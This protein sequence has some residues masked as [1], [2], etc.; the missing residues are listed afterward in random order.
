[1]SLFL[2]TFFTIYGGVHVYAYL[3][4]RN[5][6]SPGHV[7]SVL[8]GLFMVLMIVAP[9][10][11][12]V[13]EQGGYEFVA[14]V[15]A[16]LG[17]IWMALAFLFF[18]SSLAVDVINGSSILI[19][20]LIGSGARH[21]LISH[22]AAVIAPML[23]SLLINV[24][25]YFEARH[26]LVERLVIRT[27]KIP[28]DKIRIVQISD[29]HLGLIV[30]AE[31]LKKIIDIIKAEDPDIL[32]STGDLVDAQI[33]HLPGLSEMLR[34]VSARYGKFA[35]TGNHEYYAGIDRALLFI[36]DSGFKVLRSGA[37]YTGGISVVG[38]DDPSGIQ[39]GMDKRPDEA[40]VFSGLPKDRF[41]LVLRHRPVIGQYTEGLFDL[42]LSGH[43][44]KGQIFPFGYLSALSYPMNAGRF[45]LEGGSMLYV[46]RGTGT[47]GPPIRFLSPPEVT[48]ID[49]VRKRPHPDPVI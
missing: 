23:L 48:V 12:R 31:R 7:P 11:V 20:M 18:C 15:A 21:G 27:D 46:S 38:F 33:N 36:K 37:V 1:M 32:V 2:L 39:M 49:L 3:K 19:R 47:W 44:H 34:G 29:L 26:V 43:T 30:R 42:Q 14:R 45:L 8:L 28:S 13:L 5:A 4:I 22:K 16:W 6:F 40:A 9:V 10:L 17:Y 35:I 24:Y 25:G 41:R